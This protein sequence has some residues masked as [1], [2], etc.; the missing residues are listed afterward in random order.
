MRI[1]QTKS[2]ALFA[3]VAAFFSVVVPTRNASAAIDGTT[4]VDTVDLSPG[5]DAFQPLLTALNHATHKLY[6]V[7]G[8]NGFQKF[9]V[10]V[11]DTR[12]NQALAG[13]D[14]GIYTVGNFS[15]RV[16]PEAIAVDE[17]SAGNK[18]FIAAVDSNASAA[19][20][21]RIIDGKTDTN[22]TNQSTDIV[23]PSRGRAMA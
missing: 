6:V 15:P 13:I 3:A 18:I 12:T 21:I 1:L 23:I 5:A 22:T 10:K 19:P 8:G 2:I 4:L 16:Y 17:T 14:L 11:I 20:F 9:A 7:G